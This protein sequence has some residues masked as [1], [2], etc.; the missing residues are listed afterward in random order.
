[1]TIT[2]DN[3]QVEA[4]DLLLQKKYALEIL[5]GKKKIEVRSFSDHYISRF[6]DKEA[7]KRNEAKGL[8]MFDEGAESEFNAIDFIHFHN[9][10]NSWYLDV[11][12]ESIGMCV[13]DSQDIEPLAEEFD[14]FKDYIA[15]AKENDKLP[16]AERPMIFYIE[17]AEIV[18]TN[19]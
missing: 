14:D 16:E 5:S 11:A 9:Y 12:I 15:D 2:V 10:N 6:L 8:T 1:M 18:S 13:V 17:L 4:Y 19:L 7:M 3:Q